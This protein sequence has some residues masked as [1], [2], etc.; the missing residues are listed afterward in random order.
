MWVGEWLGVCGWVYVGG[1]VPMCFLSLTSL[2]SS[3]FP[4]PALHACNAA[5]DCRYKFCV[6]MENSVRQDYV[7]EKIWDA[8]GAGCIPVYLG[9]SNAR[10]FVPD[11]DSYIL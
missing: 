9:F 7:T 1:C 5:A 11:P 3:P 6:A 10:D 4:H 8:L 2:S